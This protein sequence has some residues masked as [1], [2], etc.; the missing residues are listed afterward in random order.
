[1]WQLWAQN[2]NKEFEKL[3]PPQSA[4]EGNL[5]LQVLGKRFGCEVRLRLVDGPTFRERVAEPGERGG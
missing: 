5:W 4:V 2:D 3:G 1:M